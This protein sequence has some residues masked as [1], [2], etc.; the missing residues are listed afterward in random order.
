MNRPTR[1]VARR[2]LAAVFFGAATL[3][4]V[5][6]HAFDLPELMRALAAEPAGEARFTEQRIVKGLDG[7]L[8]A[9]GT[10]RYAPPDRLVQHTLQPRDE[11]MAVEG[12]TVS[13]TRGSRTRTLALDSIPEMLGLVEAMRG[14]LAGNGDLLQRYFRATASGSAA[15]WTLDLVPIDS[16]L[17]AQVRHLRL[18]GSGGQVL[19]VEMFYASG[20]QS[21]MTIVPMTGGTEVN[22]PLP[23]G[24]AAPMP[25]RPP[26]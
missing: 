8:E 25:A 7:P 26:S 18:T 11:S 12:N 5:P 24:E 17:S 22:P 23:K 20:D 10:L 6:A 21:T 14:T 4:T 1:E 16:R 2:W 3:A 13:L 15:S 9:S 19:G